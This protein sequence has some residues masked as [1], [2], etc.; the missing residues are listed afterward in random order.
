[1][2]P[3]TPAHPTDRRLTRLRV[4]AVRALGLTLH[5]T[6]RTRLDEEIQT[7]VDLLTEEYVARGMPEREARLAARRAFGSID[8]IKE[9]HHDQR[10]LPAVESLLQDLRFAVRV[11][12]RDRRFTIAAVASLALAIG[13]NSSV[14]TLINMIA[15]RD[16]P[17]DQA[18][19][20]VQVT[21]LDGRGSIA[22][23][24]EIEY[25]S[26]Q[27]STAASAALAAHRDGSMIVGDDTRAPERIQGSV[28][29]PEA[30]GILRVAPVLGRDFRA[31]D[32]RPGAAPVVMLG[33]RLW[34]TRYGADPAVVG[35][36]VRVNGVA[37]TVVGVMPPGF[38]FPLIAQLWQPLVVHAGTTPAAAPPRNLIVF[39][40]LADGIDLPRARSEIETLAS[41]LAPAPGQP[42]GPM[43][44]VVRPLGDSLGGGASQL[45]LT[46]LAM[47]SLVLL[48][49]CANIATL[50]L[51]RAAARRREIA[52]RA[53]L[54]ATRW[55]IV[56]QLLVE[57]LTLA[58]LG[59]GLGLL[60]SRYG[61]RLLSA[62]FQ[63][64]EPGASLEETTPYWLDLS[65]DGPVYGFAV[66]LTLGAVIAF[67]LLPAAILSRAGIG[68]TLKQG[69]VS[70]WTGALVVVQIA[71]TMVLLTG[72]G[73]IFRSFVARYQAD[74]VVD[75]DRLWT[76]RVGMVGERYASADRRA[77]LLHS[78]EDRLAAMP[79]DAA[80][81]SETP[82]AS[83]GE[84]RALQIEGQPR[85]SSEQPRRVSYLAIGRDYFETVRQPI[86][87][88]RAWTV[89]DGASGQEGVVVN[90]RLA[91]MYFSGQEPVG[92][93][94]RLTL[95]DANRPGPWLTIVGVARGTPQLMGRGPGV[96]VVYVPLRGDPTPPHA[97]S[98]ILRS[99][100]GAAWSAILREELR[101]IDP[102]LPLYAIETV[103]TV[104]ARARTPQR[105]LGT[106]FGLVASIALIVVAVGVFALT[107]HS[108]AQQTHDIGVRIAFGATT[109][110]VMWLFVRRAIWQLG[111][112]LV[113]GISGAL[114]VGNV[115]RQFLVDTPP[116]DPLTIVS[117]ICLLIV[118]SLAATLLPARKAA[119]LDPTAALRSE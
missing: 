110:R 21:L 39:G 37:S 5:R 17:F 86:V 115:F 56:R 3:R 90:D 49:A 91:T 6:R 84:P 23:I 43:H 93:R 118:V 105:L 13:V 89:H 35:M 62:G 15:I 66:L 99:P 25:R 24:S 18:D 119:R 112:G 59:G 97:A 8:R 72:A 69:R 81:A 70:R 53:A 108:V 109:G 9:T 40:R 42:H 116:R 76:M 51:A 103:E 100:Q 38:T 63:V 94:I 30:F 44:S 113:L 28:V 106:W 95:Q 117:A 80:I 47:V 33:D 92:Q 31:E 7:H 96:P 98:L 71:L 45:L 1:M 78:L 82:L 41:R 60:L 57:C 102:D 101:G 88:G 104:V 83:S 58:A 27:Q 4:W 61:A 65:M 111:A 67:G 32:A 74:P 22:G 75:V 2:P 64:I 26:L 85:S 50:L 10:G 55:R 16:L 87:R 34:R 107:A 19:R 11:L 29:T 36:T 77:R 52:V 73:L 48:I 79:V 12:G 14:F 46:F 114:T 54:G 20:L 68:A